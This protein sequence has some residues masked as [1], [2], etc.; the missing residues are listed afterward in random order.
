MNQGFEIA[1]HVYTGCR[2]WPAVGTTI[3]EDGVE[4]SHMSRGAAN[5]LYDQQLDAFA[6]KYKGVPPPVSSRIDC[7]TWGDYDTQPQVELAHGIRFD[8]NYYYWPEK[9]VRNRPGLF[10]EQYKV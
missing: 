3:D 9:W 7:V 10:T 6:A 4:V 8:T 5:A 2:D 1:L